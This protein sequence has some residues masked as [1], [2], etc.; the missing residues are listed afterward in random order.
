MKVQIISDLHL[1]YYET[2]NKKILF[3]NII[4]PETEYLFLTGDVCKIN[5]IYF[6]PFLKYISKNWKKVFYVL[7]NHEYYQESNTIKCYDKL[8]NIYKKKF[9]NYPNIYFFSNIK[10]CIYH[11][12]HDN[13]LYLLIGNTMWSKCKNRGINDT[14]HIYKD[15]TSKIDYNWM[16]QQYNDCLTNLKPSNYN[17]Y[18]SNIQKLYPNS[19]LKFILLTHFPI[20]K[21]EITSWNGYHSENNNIHTYFCNDINDAQKINGELNKYDIMIGGHTHYSY[22]INLNILDKNI[23]FISNQKGYPDEKYN[24]NFVENSIFII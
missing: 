14:T 5:C 18:I 15:L 16:C 17:N 3:E 23:R 6:E 2:K 11:I 8:N 24:N 22:D 13:I 7:G 21:Y 10:K 1:D 9:L 19:Q 20:S 4:K 12:Y